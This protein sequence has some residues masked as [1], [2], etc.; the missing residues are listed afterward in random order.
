MIRKLQ[1]EYNVVGVRGAVQIFL[2]AVLFGCP[3]VNHRVFR[4]PLGSHPLVPHC[5]WVGLMLWSTRRG[6]C[7]WWHE[8]IKIV[9]VKMLSTTA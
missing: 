6:P 1:L 8:K 7:E 2:F 9:P 3:S 5:P 4:N